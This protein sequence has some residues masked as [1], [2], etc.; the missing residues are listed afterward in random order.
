MLFLR[1]FQDVGLKKQNNKYFEIWIPTKNLSFLTLFNP[2]KYFA[3]F[4]KFYSSPYGISS[5][6]WVQ[7]KWEAY[8]FFPQDSFIKLS[9]FA[10]WTLKCFLDKLSKKYTGNPFFWDPQRKKYFFPAN[11]VS[12]ETKIFK[13]TE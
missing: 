3:F 9:I 13:V 10:S 8:C 1:A 6:F 5:E 4:W 2:G 7:W 11:I 12:K